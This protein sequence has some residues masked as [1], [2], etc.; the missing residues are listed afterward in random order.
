[1]T[2]ALT[3]EALDLLRAADAQR[4]ALVHRT[5]LIDAVEVPVVTAHLLDDLRFDGWLYVQ[6]LRLGVRLVLPTVRGMELLS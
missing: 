6:D 5:Y 2:A 3:D 4:I 1:M